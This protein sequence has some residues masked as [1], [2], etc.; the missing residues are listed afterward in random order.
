MSKIQLKEVLMVKKL[1]RLE[2]SYNKK[3]EKW[4]LKDLDKN[5]TI[6][7]TNTKAELIEGGALKNFVGTAGGSVRIK[8]LDNEIQEERTYPK[9][10]DPKKSKG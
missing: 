8:K 5:R 10:A 1:R 3:D 6:A 2:V 7:Q 9:A 4:G